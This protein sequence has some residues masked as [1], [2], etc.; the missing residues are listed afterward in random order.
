MI[1]LRV[2]PLVLAL[3]AGTPSLAGPAGPPAPQVSKLSPAQQAISAYQ[4]NWVH[5]PVL[6]PCPRPKRGEIVV[7]GNGRAGSPDRLPLPD[8]RGPPDW[9][10]RPIGELPSTVAALG[11]AKGAGP[12]T[13]SGPAPAVQ[14]LEKV[15][16]DGVNR[17][18]GGQM[19]ST[20]FPMGWL[21]RHRAPSSLTGISP[22]SA[23][24]PL[25]TLRRHII[26]L[27]G[28]KRR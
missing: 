10:R 26:L 14:A 22:I 8:E 4:A 2:W 6:E 15:L 18:S 23:L 21:V 16:I 3:T 12:K 1:V 19:I 24:Q 25:L 5:R 27:S 9:T 7:C 17:I 28:H 20:V 13:L 11:G